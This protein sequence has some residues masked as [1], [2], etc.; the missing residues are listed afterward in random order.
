MTIRNFQRRKQLNQV[1]YI[2]IKII[3]N[4]FSFVFGNLFKFNPTF[5]VELFYI[6]RP[7]IYFGSIMAF[8]KN[9][10]IPLFINLVIDVIV[11]RTKKRPNEKFMQQKI[12]FHEYAYRYGRLSVYLL[13][14]PIFSI[15]TKPFIE[16]IL[17]TFRFSERIINFLI[18][19]L[20][21]F[22]K[23]YYIL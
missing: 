8:G 4:I 16:K 18:R 20:T 3:G 11:L 14:E 15:I 7:I 6:L 12:Y 19:V 22:T 10:F 5:I 17:K 2:I 9:S 23:C 21:Y 1:K 13:R